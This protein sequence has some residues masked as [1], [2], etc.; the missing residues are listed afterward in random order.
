MASKSQDGKFALTDKDLEFFK[1]KVLFW[2]YRLGQVDWQLE[3]EW[4]KPEDEGTEIASCRYSGDNKR[5]TITVSRA[6]L[7]PV[8]KN[9][10]NRYAFHEVMHLFFADIADFAN[11]NAPKGIDVNRLEHSMIRTLENVIFS[12]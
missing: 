7:E 4:G 1:E 6:W 8:D 12:D 9:K 11:E 2:C 3:V 5:A 10:L